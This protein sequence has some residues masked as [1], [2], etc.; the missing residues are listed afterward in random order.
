MTVVAFVL[1]LG[2]AVA[3]NLVE[4]RTPVA[5]EPLATISTDTGASAPVTTTPSSDSFTGNPATGE[6]SDH[7]TGSNTSDHPT[8]GK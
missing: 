6:T 2:T 4:S 5:E 1:F 8:G 7:P 3:L